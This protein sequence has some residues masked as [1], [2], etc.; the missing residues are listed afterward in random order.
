MF[1]LLFSFSSLHVSSSNLDQVVHIVNA[2]SNRDQGGNPAA[3][4]LNA[5]RLSKEKMQTIAK[6]VGD[7]KLA[8]LTVFVSKPENPKNDY[9]LQFFTPVK[10]IPHCGHATIAAFNYLIQSGAEKRSTFTKET[11]DG[12]RKIFIKGD[13]TFMEQHAPTYKNIFGSVS[14]D[15]LSQALQIPSQEFITNPQPEIVSTGNQFLI[16]GVK[17]P[18]ILQKIK[19]NLPIIKEISDR[20][21][22]IAFYVFALGRNDVDAEARMFAPL[23]GIDEESAS[24][25]AAASLGCYLYDKYNLKKSFFEIEQGRFMVNPSISRIYV[26]LKVEDEKIKSHQVGGTARYIKH[27]KL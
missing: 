13:R 9:R 6:Q 18:A 7:L 24:G 17:S 8:R 3:I 2:F 25:T 26:N 12:T 11:I 21:G 15:E 10:Q 1:F 23:Y 14:L 4:V 27:R 20:L 22:L 19:P 5:D 16:I